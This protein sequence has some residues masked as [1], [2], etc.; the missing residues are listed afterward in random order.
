M[1]K[2]IITTYKYWGFT[3]DEEPSFFLQGLIMCL[4]ILTFPLWIWFYLLYRL[5]REIGKLNGKPKKE[6]HEEDYSYY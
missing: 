2:E 3:F 4:V 1:R 6:E 5:I